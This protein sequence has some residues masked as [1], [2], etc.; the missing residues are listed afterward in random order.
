M[1]LLPIEGVADVMAE[2]SGLPSSG[3]RSGCLPMKP[4]P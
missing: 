3:R 2:H 1:T 4:R